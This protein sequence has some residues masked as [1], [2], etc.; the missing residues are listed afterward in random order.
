MCIMIH[1]RFYYFIMEIRG[2]IQIAYH[3]FL[4]SRKDIN[5]EFTKQAAVLKSLANLSRLLLVINEAKISPT[6]LCDPLSCHQVAQ[7]N[8]GGTDSHYEERKVYFYNKFHT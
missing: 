8:G 1:H 3:H 2:I 7:H 4:G 5:S 6:S